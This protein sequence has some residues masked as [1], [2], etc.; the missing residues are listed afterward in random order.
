MFTSKK[1]ARL[2]WERNEWQ[3]RAELAA[4]KPP[5][6]VPVRVRLPLWR[7]TLAVSW[8]LIIGVLVGGVAVPH[9]NDRP[10][11]APDYTGCIS[12]YSYQHRIP[13]NQFQTLVNALWACEVYQS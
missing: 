1:V 9:A 12:S 13:D 11:L 10:S 4:A 7:R 5:V 3:R 8:L 2:E 6:V